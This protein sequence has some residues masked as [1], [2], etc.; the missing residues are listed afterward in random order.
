MISPWSR[1]PSFA[2]VL[3]IAAAALYPL[4]D[5]TP[6]GDAWYF[7]IV[8][9]AMAAAFYRVL[10]ES[11]RWPWFFVLGF[12]VLQFSGGL[13][14]ARS[15]DIGD[16]SRYI[17]LGDAFFVLSYFSAMAGLAGLSQSVSPDRKTVAWLNCVIII[18]AL[19]LF[20]WKFLLSPSLREF[21]VWPR[22]DQPAVLRVW[23][24]LAGYILLG[25]ATWLA[26]TQSVSK[27]RVT[28]LQWGL[29]LWCVAESAFH[30]TS[31][32]SDVPPWWTRT[33]WLFAYVLI[34]GALALPD[35]PEDRAKR[36][37]SESD[38]AELPFIG[39]AAA[40]IPLVT[41]H[42]DFSPGVVENILVVT[43][44]AV[45]MALIW[46]R[47]MRIYRHMKRVQDDLLRMSDTD[48]VSGAWNRRYLDRVLASP[49]EALADGESLVI[50]IVLVDHDQILPRSAQDALLVTVR[51][52]LARICQAD[53]VIGRIAEHKFVVIARMAASVELFHTAAWRIRNDFYE[54]LACGSMPETGLARLHIGVAHSRNSQQSA[55]AVLDQACA[56]AERA[57]RKSALI[58]VDDQR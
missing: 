42:D 46:F 14:Q 25:M 38:R 48:P 11:P 5:T 20:G 52:V 32:S 50:F 33:L 28:L 40:S 18:I 57:R 54:V 47:F 34:A 13:I 21:G 9:V 6:A 37:Q 44:T 23:Y 3:G 55:Y 26:T 8:L 24:P 56:R 29:L 4:V 41:W 7:G 45:M 15:D 30:L 12:L 43:V 31:L 36:N 10:Q 19:M 58:V 1:A 53:D 17:S 49:P 22:F 16:F 51:K 2:L 39:L 27:Q 35:Q